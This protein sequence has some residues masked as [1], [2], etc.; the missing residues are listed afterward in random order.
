[1]H[2]KTYPNLSCMVWQRCTY[3]PNY[4][5]STMLTCVKSLQQSISMHHGLRKWRSSWANE[6]LG[7]MTKG[8]VVKKTRK[9]FYPPCISTLRE[10]NLWVSLYKYTYSFHIQNTCLNANICRRQYERRQKG[11]TMKVLL[12]LSY[13][14]FHKIAYGQL[15][16]NKIR[17]GK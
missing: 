2:T 5:T 11:K 13:W 3:E 9:Q 10:F 12:K 14:L 6:F 15:C 4:Q 7:V 1:M 16:G 8:E 17:C